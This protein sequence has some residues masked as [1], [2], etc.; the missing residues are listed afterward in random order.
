V[1]IRAGF[2]VTLEGGEG[3]GKSTL[4]KRLADVCEEM[5]RTPVL[6]R[7]PGG[8]PGADAIRA[9]LVRGDGDRWSALSETLLFAAARADHLERVI[10]PALDAG[11]VVICDRYLASTYAYQV[12]G[13][14]LAEADFDAINAALRP[15]APD[16]TFLLDIDPAIG[17]ARSRGASLGEDRYE[18]LDAAFHARVRAAFIDYA[19]RLGPEAR[20][21]DAGA[22]AD[23]IAAQAI[24]V[25]KGRLA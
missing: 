22:P 21:L 11:K 25:L 6:T 4:A 12:G 8:T 23:A 13:R 15:V 17:V 24:A 16:L 5:G 18:R 2:L 19:N 20:I 10:R 9:L 14:G 3:A 7:E 1:S